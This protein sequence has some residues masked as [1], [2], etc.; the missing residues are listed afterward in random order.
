MGSSEAAN[1]PIRGRDFT[2]GESASG[3]H[4]TAGCLRVRDTKW[5]AG[6]GASYVC[7]RGLGWVRC[8]WLLF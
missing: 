6:I 2:H 7:R 4:Y 8:D 3:K 1:P 5:N